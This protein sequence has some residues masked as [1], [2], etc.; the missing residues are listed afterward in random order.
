[1]NLRGHRVSNDL[2][3]KEVAERLGICRES[4]RKK[5]NGMLSLSLDEGFELADLYGITIE[6]LFKA[7]QA[8][9]R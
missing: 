6:E 5:E 3:Q 1:M 2:K 4:Y 9:K 8:T 7:Y